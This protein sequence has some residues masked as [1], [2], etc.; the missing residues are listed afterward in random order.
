MVA[1]VAN[2]ASTQFSW[3]RVFR[4]QL[5]VSIGLQGCL[6]G[7]KKNVMMPR[8]D[9]NNAINQLRVQKADVLDQKGWLICKK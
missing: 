7:R 6:P 1:F 9:P 3:G 5:A 2:G 8:L 4:K